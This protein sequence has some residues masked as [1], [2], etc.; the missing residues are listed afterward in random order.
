VSDGCA[1]ACCGC[2]IAP[3]LSG[4]VVPANGGKLRDLSLDYAP[5][6]SAVSSAARFQNYNWA[7]RP[8]A[9]NVQ[10]VAANIN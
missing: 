5:A 1:A 6:I 10:T 3:T 9:V 4:T 7:A 2:W 8:R